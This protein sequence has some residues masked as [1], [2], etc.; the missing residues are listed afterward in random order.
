MPKYAGRLQEA[1]MVAE[2][3]LYLID[4][5]YEQGKHVSVSDV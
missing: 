1:S 3:I 4:N 2:K 5:Q